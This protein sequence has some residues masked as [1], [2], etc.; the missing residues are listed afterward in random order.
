MRRRQGPTALASLVMAAL[1]TVTVA[2]CAHP[3]QDLGPLP[4]RFSG[5]PLPA[6][7]VVSEVTSVLAAEGVTVEREPS[8]VRGMCSERLSGH[9]APETV[10]AALEAAFA[11]ARSEHGWQTGPDMGSETLT[12]TK[13]NWTLVA[14][15]PPKPA[16][17]LQ[18][19]VLMSLMC[20][21]GGGTS[22]A[23]TTPSSSPSPSSPALTPP[24]APL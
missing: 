17:G 10:D 14:G 24:P 4:P 23:P 8:N 12:L 9:H 11:R 21:D 15:F 2:A 20:V 18:A 5:P 13:G 6:D 7:T 3:L 19:P 16:N 22:S 1:M